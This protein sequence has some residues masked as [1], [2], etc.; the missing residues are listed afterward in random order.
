[1]EKFINAQNY[2]YESALSELKNGKKESHW[3]WFIFPQVIGLGESDTSEYYAIKSLEEAEIFLN[4]EILGSRLNEL[5]E[6][7][8][9]LET[10][11]P[12]EVFGAIDALKLKSSMTLFD[13]IEPNSIFSDVLD[14]FYNGSRCETTIDICNTFSNSSLRLNRYNG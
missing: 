7:L 1:M 5:C 9:T 8:L 2:S 11:H 14:K 3:M 10:N 6:V 12:E 4:N 13:Y